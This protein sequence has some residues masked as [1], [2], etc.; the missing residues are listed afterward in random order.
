MYLIWWFS[1]IRPNFSLAFTVVNTIF[2]ISLQYHRAK[3]T[4][5]IV[6]VWP[7][8]KFF[9]PLLLRKFCHVS[10]FSTKANLKCNVWTSECKREQI[11][12]KAS[13]NTGNLIK[14]VPIIKVIPL[15]TQDKSKFQVSLSHFHHFVAT[16]CTI[17]TCIH[18]PKQPLTVNYI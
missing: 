3:L 15:Y 7:K 14:N 18:D 1:V 17:I 13:P 8:N 9:F 11:Q 2:K 12:V 16:G 4:R 6:I 5:L 10:I